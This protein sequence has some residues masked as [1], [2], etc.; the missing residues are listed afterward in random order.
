MGASLEVCVCLC[1]CRVRSVKRKKECQVVGVSR[2]RRASDSGRKENEETWQLK[3]T[4]GSGTVTQTGV[5]CELVCGNQGEK[6]EE[7]ALKHGQ[8]VAVCTKAP[9]GW[10]TTCC[11][12][13]SWP[14]RHSSARQSVSSAP[15]KTWLLETMR[16]MP[17]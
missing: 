11:G 10:R 8:D 16:A 1:E 12:R 17:V 5:G 15:V 7:E 3:K 14:P 2:G 13:S 6:T 9:P 4:W